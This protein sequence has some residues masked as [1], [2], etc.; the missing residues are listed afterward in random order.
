MVKMQ[1]QQS[2]GDR[3]SLT[4]ESGKSGSGHGRTKLILKNVLEK[5]LGSSLNIQ[6]DGKDKIGAGNSE[7]GIGH[8]KRGS[9]L[10]FVGAEDTSASSLGPRD[11]ILAMPL[12]YEPQLTSNR[13][14]GIGGKMSWNATGSFQQKNLRS[15]RGGQV[16]SEGHSFAKRFSKSVE[17]GRLFSDKNVGNESKVLLSLKSVSSQ[18][19]PGAKFKIYALAI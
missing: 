17:T 15:S 19:V 4:K 8:Q 2:L 16:G 11:H 14:L 10:T 9:I 5:K 12:K 18:G 7:Y 3:R 6:G 13:F 1:K